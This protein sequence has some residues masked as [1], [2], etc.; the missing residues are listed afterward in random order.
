MQKKNIPQN[1][2]IWTNDEIFM[3]MTKQFSQDSKVLKSRNLGYLIKHPRLNYA[4][5][6]R[7]KSFDAWP[8]IMT[9]REFYKGIKGWHNII[10]IV[11]EWNLKVIG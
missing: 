2:Q 8:F 11:L 7:V 9:K 1:T 10:E 5:G 3:T 4:I 6:K